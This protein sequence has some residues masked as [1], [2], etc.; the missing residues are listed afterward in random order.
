[1]HVCLRA[2]GKHAI[3]NKG[4]STFICIFSRRDITFIL[5]FYINNVDP[6]LAGVT[7]PTTVQNHETPF[8]LGENYTW[9]FWKLLPASFTFATT[10]CAENAYCWNVAVHYDCC[11]DQSLQGN[12]VNEWPN[13]F[14]LPVN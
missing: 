14:I 6:V 2:F 11:I 5:L 4:L 7:S 8:C 12:D 9:E 1:M 13:I 10:E 3:A